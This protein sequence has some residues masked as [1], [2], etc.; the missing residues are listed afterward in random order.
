MTTDTVGNFTVTV[1]GMTGNFKVG[2]WPPEPP[3]RPAEFEVS[4]LIITPDEAELGEDVI[5]SFTVT[6]IG[7]QTGSYLVDLKIDGVTIARRT[8]ELE[9]GESETR[10][11]ELTPEML[12]YYSVE[13]GDPR[14][15][16]L[17][18]SFTVK[19]P[20]K[21][22]EFEA[23][24]LVVTPQEVVPGG[25][26]MVSATITNIG[27]ESGSHTVELKLD[28][29]VV[30]SESITLNGGAS[31]TVTLTTTSEA[32]GSHSVEID[33]LSGSFTVEAPAPPKKTLW[34][35]I[36]LLVVLVAILL[37]IWRRTDWIDQLRASLK[38]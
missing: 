25:T 21:P 27:E 34:I 16:G 7:E 20:P 24:N 14:V 26:I 28:G 8:G 3:L 9:P 33:G 11:Y 38:R 2:T 23:S 29:Q 37:Y 13:V 1:H 15:L 19:A 18:G 10:S 36:V 31:V 32:E 6:N 4:D 30:D 12:G 5:I 22:A 35:W 17:T